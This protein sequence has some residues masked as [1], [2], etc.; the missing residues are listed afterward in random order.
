MPIINTK[1]IADLFIFVG[2]VGAAVFS[3]GMARWQ[4]F[5]SARRKED[6]EDRKA[7]LE[8]LRENAK[9][10]AELEAKEAIL[11][12]ELENFM[13]ELNKQREVEP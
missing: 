4:Q 10:V 3:W 6:E 7:L 12:Q 13:R 9:V 1:D 8:S 2:A 11:K 5:R